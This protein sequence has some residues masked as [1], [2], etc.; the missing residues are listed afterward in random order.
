[1][2][3]SSEIVSA[4][5]SPT[6]VAIACA[7]RVLDGRPVKQVRELMNM[8]FDQ[9]GSAPPSLDWS[10]PESWIDER[11]TGTLQ[12]LA[13]K[14]WEGSGKALNPRHLYAQVA[15]INRLRLLEPVDGLYRLGDHG[16]RFLSGDE[17]ILRELVALRSSKRR[18]TSPSSGRGSGKNA[19]VRPANR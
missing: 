18:R 5:P 7:V 6:Y 16:R 9:A 12:A 3:H 13:R 19:A 15:F 11:L 14:V 4:P 10:D 2:P 17:A 8:I 1:M